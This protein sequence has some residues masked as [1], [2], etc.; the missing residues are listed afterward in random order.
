MNMDFHDCFRFV[1]LALLTIV[2]CSGNRLN[3]DEPVEDFRFKVEVLATGMEQPLQLKL[4]PDGRIFF[5][6]LKGSLKIWKPNT[7]TVV[8][9]GIVP[10]FSE[11]ENGFLGFALDPHFEKNNWIYLFYS[12]SNHVGQRLSRFVMRGDTLDFAS[13]KIMLEFGEQRREC[14]HHAGSLAF[15]PDGNLFIST[16]DNTHPFGD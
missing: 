16:G 4:A 6:E 7:R 13:E 3:A 9:A 8:V 1:R 10:T 5:N 2:V 14:C 11:Q 12:P 15:G